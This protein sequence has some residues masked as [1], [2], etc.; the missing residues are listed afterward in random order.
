MKLSFLSNKIYFRK[1]R[2]SHEQLSDEDKNS[3]S[4]TVFM[5]MKRG[6]MIIVK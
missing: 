2:G 6:L 3:L 1:K 4:D 5:N